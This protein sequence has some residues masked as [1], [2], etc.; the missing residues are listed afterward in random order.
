MSPLYYIYIQ[1]LYPGVRV[2]LTFYP[3]NIE[4]ETGI[5]TECNASTYMKLNT[6]FGIK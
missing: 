5:H 3:R 1:L 6:L 2:D 4:C